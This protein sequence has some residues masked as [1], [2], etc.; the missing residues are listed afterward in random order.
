MNSN[1]K[2]TM[3]AV[4]F[5]GGMPIQGVMESHRDLPG[6]GLPARTGHESHASPIVPEPV[7]PRVFPGL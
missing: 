4:V 5:S 2:P 7:W 3:D 1:D 6:T